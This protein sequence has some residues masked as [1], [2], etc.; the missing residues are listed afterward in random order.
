MKNTYALEQARRQ[1]ARGMPKDLLWDWLRPIA[2]YR[3]R[4]EIIDALA[5]REAA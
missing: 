3:E 5:V 1:L 2:S 4:T